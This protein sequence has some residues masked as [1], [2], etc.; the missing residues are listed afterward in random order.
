[1]LLD[2]RQLAKL[3][4]TYTDALVAGR[5]TPETGRV[6]TSFSLAST[7][8]GRLSSTEPNLQNIPVR[9]EEGRKIRT[10]FIAEPGQVLISADYSQIELRLLA[11]IGRHPALKRAFAEGARHPRHDRLGD[12][13]RAGGGHAE[14][15]RRRAKA[16]NFGIIYGIS[17]F[18]LAQPAR[19]PAAARRA[20]ISRPISS[21]SPASAPIWTPCAP[22]CASRATSRRCSGAR[23]TSPKSTR[24]SGDMRA[25]AERAAINAPIQGTAADIIRRAMIRM[26]AALAAA[27]VCGAHA[28]A[29]A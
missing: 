20:T 6:H 26:P 23:S 12:V 16:I 5:S 1:M 13:R 24:R 9:T 8:T 2:W 17:A 10:A 25:F 19:H 7:T 18:G 15:V 21:A 22:R 29:G 28:A 3:K 14:R 11:H 4:G 27:K